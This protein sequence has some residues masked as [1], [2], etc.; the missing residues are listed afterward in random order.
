[1]PPAAREP[2]SKGSLDSP[3]LFGALRVGRSA[4][5]DCPLLPSSETPPH[6][7]FEFRV[8]AVAAWLLFA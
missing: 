6:H 3:K 4:A 2:F 7:P 5:D 8:T 1:M